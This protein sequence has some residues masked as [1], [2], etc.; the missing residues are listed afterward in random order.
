[1]LLATYRSKRDFARTPEPRGSHARPSKALIFVVQI[2]QMPP[3]V[4]NTRSRTCGG[5]GLSSLLPIHSSTVRA[6][7]FV[8]AP[9]VLDPARRE[10]AHHHHANQRADE[11]TNQH[12]I[13]KFHVSPN[14]NFAKLRIM[15]F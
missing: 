11:Q 9:D 3:K 1:M 10:H 4:R 14:S 12:A 8:P 2:P 6:I 13:E 5:T 15:Y 7:I